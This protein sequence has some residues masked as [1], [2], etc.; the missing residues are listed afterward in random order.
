MYGCVLSFPVHLTHLV[1]T[2]ALSPHAIL[3]T[4]FLYIYGF[5]MCLVSLLYTLWLLRGVTEQR[6][7]LFSCFLAVPQGFVRQ[8]ALKEVGVATISGA[9]PNG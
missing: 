9:T 5:S 8:L 7:R 1:R 3:Q 6:Y 2:L 4:S